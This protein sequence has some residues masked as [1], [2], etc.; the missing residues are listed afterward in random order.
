[1]GR[2]ADGSPTGGDGYGGEY[3]KGMER[4][5]DGWRCDPG[6]EEHRE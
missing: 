4:L 2:R 6:C 1:M 3:R 5:V